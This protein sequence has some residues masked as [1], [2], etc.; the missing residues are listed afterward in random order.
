MLRRC[1]WLTMLVLWFVCLAVVSC[2]SSTGVDD[3]AE[4]DGI[5]PSGIVDLT[6]I[7]FTN[8]SVALTWTAPGDDSTSGTA[9]AYDVRYSF[10]NDLWTGWDS[11]MVVQGVPPPKSAGSAESLN[12]TGLLEDST[13]YFAISTRDEEYNWSFISNA[14]SA[15]CYNDFVVD[16]PDAGLE[17]AVRQA[18]GKPAG[19]IYRSEMLGLES[20]EAEQAGIQDLS[21]IEYCTGLWALILPGNQI[22]DLGP[23]SGLDALRSLNASDNEIEDLTPLA[24]LTGLEHL[25]LYGNLIDDISPLSG[26][27][28]IQVLRL[29]QNKITQVTALAGLS[30]IEY[31]N[32]DWNQIA[33][34]GP[35]VANAGL[36]D[37]DQLYLHVN[38]LSFESVTIHIPALQA[39]GVD[40]HWDLDE[41]A[42]S[43]VSDLFTGAVSDTSATLVWTAPG[44]D[45]IWGTADAYQVR[46]GTDSL[47]VAGW[48][49]AAIASG[50]PAPGEA[51]TAES[52]EVTGLE[53]STR[54]FFALKTRDE[55]DNWSD[56]SNVASGV[57]FVDVVIPI[58]DAGLE[59][60][61]RD[62]LDQPSGD[63][64][65]SD[66][67]RILQLDASSR[68]IADLAGLEQCVNISVLHLEDNDI[69]DIGKLM[70]LT[71]LTSLTLD[72]NDIT[73]ISP[74][75]GLT[76][77]Q[78]LSLRDNQVSTFE[79]LENLEN[80]EYLLFSN[81]AVSDLGPISG[82]N[83]IFIL[84]GINNNISDISALSGMP[85]LFYVFLSLNPISDLGPLAGL[86]NL[87][88]VYVE[89]AA[90]SDL[91]P[92]SGLP[93]I[94]KISIRYDQVSDIAPLVAN[95]GL[96]S[97]DEVWLE[98]NPLSDTSINSHIPALEARGVTVH[99]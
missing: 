58:P 85:M 98:N 73:D 24:G 52:M 17:A 34:I 74:V 37:G 21:G 50:A 23:L 59:A 8:S 76:A 86:A 18:L 44:D 6:V 28:R 96:G 84:E 65:K 5:S 11:A 29:E 27:F 16:I 32:L 4:D 91:S 55:A 82:L 9:A 70:G 78:S 87:R 83:K 41:T 3:V 63:I 79:A 39:R 42:P 68:G 54:Y 75:A 35:L 22:D 7:G 1:D 93:F 81:N 77:L 20:L 12:V 49:D 90:V 10:R 69:S 19:D 99:Q 92:L 45:G 80:L 60:A 72:K 43:E 71:R 31:L 94:E 46:Y 14:A 36:G 38:P 64:Y 15:K 53:T 25:S 89:Y 2:S 62:E 40:V 33:D 47:E 67:F 30:S 57:P 26:L 66:L 48:N 97:G 51:G 13:Y 61:I 56:I 95:P 88:Y